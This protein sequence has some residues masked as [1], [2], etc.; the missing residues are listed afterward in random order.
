MVPAD[1]LASFNAAPPGARPEAFSEYFAMLVATRDVRCDNVR[2]LHAAGV[3]ILAGAD[4]QLGVFPGAALHREIANLARCGLSPFQALYAA[5]AG[6]ARFVSG[7]D[8]PDF[9]IVQVGHR[10]DLL[11]I[12]GN[13]LVD[14]AAVDDIVAVVKDGRV[15][16][17]HPIAGGT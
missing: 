5:T 7:R 8:D 2:R 11:L 9:G 17:R 1:V 3:P 12:G 14:V 6:A 10:A 13:P 15:L 16:A 4:A